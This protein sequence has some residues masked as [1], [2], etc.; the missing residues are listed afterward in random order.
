MTGNKI[1]HA[2][3]CRRCGREGEFTYEMAS[4]ASF[5]SRI[6]YESLTPGFRFKDTGYALTSTISCSRCN[7]IVFPYSMS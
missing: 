3:V 7:E 5:G 1:K 6:S 4:R 2:L